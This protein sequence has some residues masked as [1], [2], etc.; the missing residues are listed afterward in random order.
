MLNPGKNNYIA[1]ISPLNIKN[2]H[3]GFAVMDLSTGDFRADEFDDKDKALRAFIKYAPVEVLY[4]QDNSIPGLDYGIQLDQDEVLT[5]VNPFWFEDANCKS[6]LLKQF[7]VS[8]LKGLDDV[9]C[10][11]L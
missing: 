9:Q 5:A 7:N 10:T 4:S 8:T 11:H 2:S 3:F 6:L 1:A